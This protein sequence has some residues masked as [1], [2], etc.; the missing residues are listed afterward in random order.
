[1]DAIVHEIR[2][3]LIDENLDNQVTVVFTGGAADNVYPLTQVKDYIVEPDL[4]LMGLKQMAV[5]KQ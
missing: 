4:V 3:K 5:E 2:N 1:M